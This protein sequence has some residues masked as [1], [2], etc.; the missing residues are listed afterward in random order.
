LRTLNLQS[1]RI[2]DVFGRHLGYALVY[3]AVTLA[4]AVLGYTA[5]FHWRDVSAQADQWS[6][7]LS[8]QRLET[9]V[10]DVRL[11]TGGAYRF[12]VPRGW[13]RDPLTPAGLRQPGFGESA[14]TMVL[15]WPDLKPCESR[16]SCQRGTASVIQISVPHPFDDEQYYLNTLKSGGLASALGESPSDVPGFTM[17]VTDSVQDGQTWSSQSRTYRPLGTSDIET[18]R[19]HL[20][21]SERAEAGS[22]DVRAAWRGDASIQVSMPTTLRREAVVI[23]EAVLALIDGVASPLN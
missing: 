3:F 6:R 18:M 23:T 4:V 16:R 7:A 11:R 5:L 17:R 2:R 22:C 1:R 21:I 19:C 12:S 15:T 9:A 10:F 8:E 20:V 13:L 14:F